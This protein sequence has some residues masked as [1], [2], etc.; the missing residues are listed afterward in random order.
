MG[1][2]KFSYSNIY[3]ALVDVC[4]SQVSICIKNQFIK[5]FKLT[6]KSNHPKALVT[7][8]GSGSFPRTNKAQRQDTQWCVQLET[9]LAFPARMQSALNPSSPQLQGRRVQRCQPS[10][11][12]LEL[13]FLFL[14][15]ICGS[16]CCLFC[17]AL[18]LW[19]VARPCQRGETQRLGVWDQ[20][21][22][23]T[24]YWCCI[25]ALDTHRAAGYNGLEINKVE[26]DI[27][28]PLPP[29]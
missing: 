5:V 1:L 12:L 17:A 6:T 21:F 20:T 7:T 18:P 9:A 28:Y 27:R 15:R 19:F 14:Y 10:L 22:V 25:Q 26:G 2:L 3:W 16:L 11:A 23:A 29:L 4:I 8:R 24:W 13:H